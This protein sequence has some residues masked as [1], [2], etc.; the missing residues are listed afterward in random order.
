MSIKVTYYRQ[1]KDERSNVVGY[2]GLYLDDLDLYLSCRYVRRKDGGFF[3]SSHSEEYQD[4]NGNKAYNNH[5][6][7]GKKFG[8]AFQ[9]K[10]QHS[11][12]AYIDAMQEKQREQQVPPPQQQAQAPTSQVQFHEQ[13]AGVPF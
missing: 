7:F 8:G 6:W 2:L 4:K 10:A 1:N 5:F 13:D 12:H 9:E 3:V 11:I